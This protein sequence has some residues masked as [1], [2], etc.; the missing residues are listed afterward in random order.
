[1]WVDRRKNALMQNWVTVVLSNILLLVHP[2]YM[3][4]ADYEPLFEHNGVRFSYIVKDWSTTPQKDEVLIRLENQNNFKVEVSFRVCCVSTTGS[5]SSDAGSRFTLKANEVQSGSLSGLFFL[6]LPDG[7]QI[8]TLQLVDVVVN[9]IDRPWGEWKAHPDYPFLLYHVR[10]GE[11]LG[12][13]NGYQWYAE[14]KNTGA[15]PVYL[16]YGMQRVSDKGATTGR[17]HIQPGETSKGGISRLLRV[18]PGQDDK[19][20]LTLDRIRAASNDEGA[21]LKPGTK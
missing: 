4:A 6:P 19:L 21:F 18:R 17:I 9:R 1:M 8:E 16:S 11:Y 20:E 10:C 12:G 15:E 2:G 5:E 7:E 14:I 13:K 3:L